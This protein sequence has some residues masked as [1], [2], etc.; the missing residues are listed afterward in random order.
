MAADRCGLYV[1]ESLEGVLGKMFENHGIH[2]YIQTLVMWET[3]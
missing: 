3:Q 1:D 2:S